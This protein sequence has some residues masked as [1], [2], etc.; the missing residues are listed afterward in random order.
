MAIGRRE[1]ANCRRNFYNDEMQTSRTKSFFGLFL[2]LVSLNACSGNKTANANA[3][4]PNANQ[5]V[6]SSG[7]TI[8][9]DD[10]EELARIIKLPLLPEEATY[11]ETKPPSKNAASQNSAPHEKRLVAVLRFSPEDAAKI[12]AAAEKYQSPAPSD[13][14]AET[15]FPP[16]LVAKSQETGDEFLKGNAYA[17]NDFLQPPYQTG[18]LTRVNDS[19]Y[20]VL[21]LTAF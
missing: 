17:A 1:I 21:E 15:W 2:M 4:A 12:V 5:T 13:I 14:D 7:E 16:E 9:Q 8:V 18:K 10:V 20:F 19:N 3:S 6:N 11:S